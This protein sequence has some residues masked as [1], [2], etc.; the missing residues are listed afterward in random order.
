MTEAVCAAFRAKLKALLLSGG[1][2]RVV[3]AA[4][5]LL[6]PAV[7][8]D[9]WVHLSTPWRVL[10][11]GIYFCAVA[12]TFYLT[13]WKPLA[14]AWSDAEILR[15]ID[16]ATGGMLLEY[17]ELQNPALKIQ[18]LESPRGK[19]LAKAAVAGLEPMAKGADIRAAFERRSVSRQVT[20][21]IA[22][23]ALLGIAA[24]LAREHAAIGLQ[25]FFNP[26]SN[27]HWPSRTVI[28][29]A[30][31]SG[32]WSVPQM[33]AFTVQATLSGV[34]PSEAQIAYKSASTGYY[35]KE[36]IPVRDGKVAYTFP[37]VRE[38]L[39]FYISGGDETTDAVQL[40]VVERPYLK[41]IVAHYKFP[42]YAGLPDKTSPSGQLL[43]LEGTQVRLVFES[44]L[45]VKRAVFALDKTA[46]EEMPCR[47]DAGGTKFEKAL[48][49]REDGAYTVELHDAHGFR[50]AKPERYEI[51]VIPDNV[52]EVELLAPGTDVVAT[53]NASFEVALKARDDFGL[54]SVELL[55]QVNDA[56]PVAL[57]DRVTGPIRQ[58][59]KLSEAR[60]TWDLRK[61]EELPDAASITYFVRAQDINPT[62]RGK[63]ETARRQI[64]IVKPSDFHLEAIE[65]AKGLL[66]EALIAWRNQLEA[67]KAGAAWLK[68]G[69]GKDDDPAWREM[70]E[71]QE[72]AMR[73]AK[74]MDSHLAILSQAYENNHMEREF[75][76]ARLNAISELLKRL[77]QEELAQISE[78]LRA[79]RPQNDADSAPERL[80]VLRGSAL[81]KATGNQKLSVLILE[82]LLRKLYDWRDLQTATITSTL[83]HERQDEVGAL[84]EKTSPKYIGKEFED[85]TDP[86]QEQLL[87]LGKQQ[88]A[89]FDT[90]TQLETQLSHQIFKAEK[91]SR[92]NVLLPLRAA[93]EGL[94]SNRVND[95]LKEAA[96]KIENNQ[97]S[98]IIK[99]QKTALRTLEAVKNGLVLAG[100]KL[101]PDEPL[102][103]NLEV[104]DAGKF[105]E[106]EVA[107]EEKKDDSTAAA[108]VDALPE[109]PLESTLPEGGDK[110]SVAL[111]AALEK[112]DDVLARARYLSEKNPAQEMP[113]FMRLKLGI[114]SERQTIATRML[115][116]AAQEASQA[117]AP[118][119]E[120]LAE[121]REQFAQ[122]AA[123]LAAK[124][125]SAGTQQLQDDAMSAIKDLLQQI[126]FEKAVEE[127]AAENK[128]RGGVDAFARPFLLREK[129]LDAFTKMLA[130]LSQ[131]RL[132]QRS[133][134]R[135][136][137][138]FAKNPAKDAPADAIE[139]KNRASAAGLE[140]Q[141]GALIQ[142]AQNASNGLS[143]DTNA[144]VKSAGLGAMVDRKLPAPAEISS[145][146]KDAA[147]AAS[148]DAAAKVIGASLQALRDLLEE[149]VQ[150]TLAAAQ[151]V[152]DE[153]KKI[154]AEEYAKANSR[155]ALLERIRGDT[156]LPPEIREKMI[157]SLAR[158]FPAKFK[159]LLTAYYASFGADTGKEKKP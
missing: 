50:E 137:G 106:V 152:E 11:L 135:T 76:A 107:K 132:N 37:E 49:L 108:N 111:R 70:S 5:A 97:P 75:M 115:E 140:T 151:K 126:A 61:M 128:R 127:S 125:V 124:D 123:L 33:E 130:T 43:G 57:S 91:Q 94:R 7:L 83:L 80:K 24:M 68:S 62:G 90:E 143:A 138:R 103:A 144:R 120:G 30:A 113:R 72:N 12:A 34:V 95:N 4:L 21:A 159:E 40:S 96:S 141:I 10:A 105:E 77:T 78:Q 148:A 59:G 118:L 64:K 133:V 32:G 142:D 55:Y 131:A 18:E 145:G 89:I 99:N 150:P 31:P 153:P 66:G 112:E 42:D 16:R 69:T 60:F 114:L 119:M 139:A 56:A 28:A 22:L 35:I 134:A 136:L 85:L 146:G 8:L 63:T 147:L 46:P 104:S 53:R 26:F 41:S 82:R 14:R 39:T 157:E 51:R 155:E 93:F 15:Y 88:R 65:N 25:R 27:R 44:S 110:L 74:S 67:W 116:R 45:P 73:A 86:E 84:T 23:C 122:S 20:V 81:N 109:V 17:F 154:S 54:K 3:I 9:W 156:K 117:S 71:K 2:A 79:A 48:M 129:D 92:K 47:Q 149:R 13:L 102:N 121:T 38:A 19:A 36:K 158:E 6:A 101:D 100:Q 52:P 1:I 87:T 58:S 29:L 98:V